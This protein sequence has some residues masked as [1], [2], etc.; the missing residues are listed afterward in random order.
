MNQSLPIKIATWNVNSIR[1]RIES[2]VNWI[3][4]TNPDILLL[5]ELK[6]TS[7][8]FPHDIIDDLGYNKAIFG[9]KTYNG[10]AILSK[11]PI[12]DIQY[13]LPNFPDEQSRYI[14]ALIS[15]P[16]QTIR[17]ASVYVP[18]GGSE[19]KEGA[20]IN[21][22]D[23]FQYKMKFFDKLS[24]HLEKNLQYNEIFLAG[25]D[26][27]LAI[28]DSD[29]FDPI[30]LKN[31]LCFHDDER[32]KFRAIL[33]SGYEDLFNNFCKNISAFSWWDYR[34]NSLELNKGYRIDYILASPKA[35]DNIANC[36]IDK[37]AIE[38]P[39]RSDHAPVICQLHKL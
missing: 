23:K 26:Y 33:N 22:T 4:L 11:Y 30:S 32:R 19:L 24:E 14:E 2:F 1:A 28:N 25:G 15:L 21:Q 38:C 3:K 8:N 10:V 36:Y 9:Q 39:K 27:N 13:N 35:Q 20:K 31:S 37:K 34:G 7:E 6:C 18:N 12:Y 5:Q 16:N 17:V 29:V